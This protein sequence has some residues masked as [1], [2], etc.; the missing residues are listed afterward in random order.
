[1]YLFIEFEPSR[2]AIKPLHHRDVPLDY[3][4]SGKNT[5]YSLHASSTRHEFHVAIRVLLRLSCGVPTRN[6][7]WGSS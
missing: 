6:L 3:S 4:V 2:S 5:L 7:V 1:M